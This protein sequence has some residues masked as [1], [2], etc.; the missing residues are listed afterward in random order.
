MA[1]NLAT[2][3][4]LDCALYLEGVRIP[5]QWAQVSATENRP[6]RA[7]IALIPLSTALLIRPRS[8]VH[9][10]YWDVPY[11]TVGTAGTWRLLFEGETVGIVTD[12]SDA[13]VSIQVT[14]EDFTTYYRACPQ[15]FVN[16]SQA[17]NASNYELAIFTG[18]T[19]FNMGN[20]NQV[21]L[22]TIINQPVTPNYG[23]VYNTITRG[24]DL[25]NSPGSGTSEG[26]TSSAPKAF[27]FRNPL[28][29]LL[30]LLQWV[31][32]G[33]NDSIQGVNRFFDEAQE[34]LHILE[35]IWFLQD[36]EM[37][38]LV[39]EQLWKQQILQ[40]QA[41]GMGEV[42]TMDKVVDKFL[43]V[44]MYSSYGILAPP[45]GG[46]P[47]RDSSTGFKVMPNPPNTTRG[48]N[49]L[50]TFWKPQ[51]YFLPP[52][53]C[54]IRFPNRVTRFS[55]SR[56]YLDEPTRLR[57]KVLQLP[58][59]TAN[60]KDPLSQPGEWSYYNPSGLNSLMT[61]EA[62]TS[63]NAY[64]NGN[65]PRDFSTDQ[66]VIQA[67]KQNITRSYGYYSSGS[68]LISDPS[69]DLFEAETG[70]H[71]EFNVLDSAT[72]A[73]IQSLSSD[74]TISQFASQLT[75][76][77]TEANSR[78]RY[79]LE[80]GDYTLDKMR[81][82]SRSLEI[83][84]PFDPNVLV[85][86]P[87]VVVDF[88]GCYF[89]EFSSVTHFL[90]GNSSTPSTT[91]I[92]ATHARHF[93]TPP[94]L[95]MYSYAQLLS[96]VASEASLYYDPITGEDYNT[97]YDPVSG[98]AIPAPGYS[99]ASY[100]PYLAAA[101]RPGNIDTVYGQFGT[102]NIYSGSG[103]SISISAQESAAIVWLRQY[104]LDCR[105][106]GNEDPETFVRRV[107]SRQASV[108]SVGTVGTVYSASTVTP[109][110]S[111]D[112]F[113]ITGAEYLFGSAGNGPVFRAH[114]GAHTN[115]KQLVVLNYLDALKVYMGKR[116]NSNA[117]LRDNRIAGAAVLLR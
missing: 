53:K 2:A 4:R 101:Y 23:I 65:T 97:I 15:Y 43:S 80:M 36:N 10:F 70:I 95:P 29:G 21:M 66:E 98:G 106:E 52:P 117:I 64:Y 87:G 22:G 32:G 24:L 93:P 71:P 3:N 59:Q 68:N 62:T 82:R 12:R 16:N 76:N 47:S 48:T 63:H 74:A 114:Q 14:A 1:E 5:F 11:N 6:A 28:A 113:N 35:H 73:F 9:I 19:P 26:G 112:A 84:G 100:P 46:N 57:T 102:S 90:S 116:S 51:T 108:T 41:S 31:G 99:S 7:T 85:G 54:N 67:A 20:P 37:T 72:F 40:Q 27:A 83:E 79:F 60:P 44:A 33:G 39:H 55:Y 61:T 34:R 17:F 75:T 107:T 18:N 110:F 111:E 91:R 56:A 49:I 8:L 81:M 105:G 92:T 78:G 96:M 42:A 103:L 104:L 38:E 109:M 115:T 45:C 86:F 58:Q 25:A 30:R 94:L 50:N 88:M 89:G 69:R 13:G 77:G